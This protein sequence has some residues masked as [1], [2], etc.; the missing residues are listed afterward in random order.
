MSL[1]EWKEELFYLY[2]CCKAHPNWPK[3]LEEAI[4]WQDDVDAKEYLMELLEMDKKGAMKFAKS[5]TV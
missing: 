4:E 3:N 5:R 2:E 1:E